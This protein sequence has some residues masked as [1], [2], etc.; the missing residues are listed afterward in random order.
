MMTGGACTFGMAGM[1]LI[2]LLLIVALMLGVGALVKYLFL[3][4]KGE[5]E[6]AQWHEGGDS[7]RHPAKYK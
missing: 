3:N 1:G 6:S 2:S 5:G 4:K 7:E